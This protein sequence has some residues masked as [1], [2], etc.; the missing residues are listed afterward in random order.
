MAHAALK[1]IR[2]SL[3]Q[4]KS[5]KNQQCQSP[6]IE[7]DTKLLKNER[8]SS[9]S[10]VWVPRQNQQRSH[11]HESL[12]SDDPS[13]PLSLD[14]EEADTDLETDRLLGQ[15]RL[16]DQGFYDEKVRTELLNIFIEQKMKTE[17]KTLRRIYWKYYNQISIGLSF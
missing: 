14:D 9:T 6:V 12:N 13:K 1:D 5:I 16:D 7:D 4:T 3:Q 10:P 11:S 2:T 17:N 8:N 15:Q